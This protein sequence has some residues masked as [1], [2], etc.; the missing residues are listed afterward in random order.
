LWAEIP[1]PFSVHMSSIAQA[2]CPNTLRI[3]ELGNADY[4]S[5]NRR[6][7]ENQR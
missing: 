4:A 7:G 1:L 6:R 3:G 2:T 5:C